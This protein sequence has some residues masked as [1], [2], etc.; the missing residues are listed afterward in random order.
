MILWLVVMLRTANVVVDLE[1][2]KSRLQASPVC[3]ISLA[4]VSRRQAGRYSTLGYVEQRLHYGKVGGR[5]EGL[6][7]ACD[8]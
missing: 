1:S 4:Y 8:P 5:A 2:L 7:G 3:K 6:S